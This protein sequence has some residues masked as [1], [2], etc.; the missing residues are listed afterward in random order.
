MYPAYP[1]LALNAA[2]SSHVIFTFLGNASRASLVGQI[3]AKLSLL[4]SVALLALAVT[5]GIF[6][7][8]GI[9]TAY[10]APIKDMM[11]FQQVETTSFQNISICF[12]KDW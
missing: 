1:A 9:S 5:G 6:R 10:N 12:G 3:P 8:A 7:T 2:L 4:V 11:P